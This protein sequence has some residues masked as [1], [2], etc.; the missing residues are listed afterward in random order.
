MAANIYEK[1]TKKEP[2]PTPKRASTEA[3]RFVVKC[4]ISTFIA[5][6]TEDN[7][8]MGKHTGLSSC[9]ALGGSK[10]SFSTFI[11]TVNRFLRPFRDITR[12]LYEDRAET[13]LA[14]INAAAASIVVLAPPVSV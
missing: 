6:L 9:E 1:D 2:Q 14:I 13:L 12:T 7:L 5:T 11:L 3:L 10:P 4:S 8:R